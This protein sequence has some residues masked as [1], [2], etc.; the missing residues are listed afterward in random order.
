[1]GQTLVP[2]KDITQVTTNVMVRDGCT[3]IIGGL[4]QQELDTTGNQIPFLGNLKYIG[5]L[6][7]NRTEN[8]IRNEVLIL[9]TPRIVYGPD[10][11][12]E[13]RQASCQWQ[14]RQAVYADRMSPLG[15]RSVSR[16]YLRMAQ[17]AQAAGQCNRAVRFAELAVQF[18]PEKLG[19]HQSA[20]PALREPQGLCR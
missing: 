14:Q 11:D 8:T 5:P 20:E 10:S 9:L 6:F 3:V 2:D 7:R 4:I 13:S 18:D 17:N 1:M 12:R 19:S 15:R 16:R